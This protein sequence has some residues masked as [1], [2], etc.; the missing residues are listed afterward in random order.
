MDVRAFEKTPQIA[1]L[2]VRL[3]EGQRLYM[4]AK[5]RNP[6]AKA[7][8]TGAVSDLLAI[9][10]SAREQ[11]LLTDVLVALT[12]QAEKD[13]RAAI[14][15]RLSLMGNVPLRLVLQLAND[16]IAVAAPVLKKSPVLSDLDLIYIIKSQGSAYWQAIA[17]R[18]SLSPQV[19]DL[20]A[21]TK[22]VPTGIVLARNDRLAL[23]DH[24]VS[25][26][27]ILA[28]SNESLARPLLARP[29]LPGSLVQEIYA[30]A[31]AAL[32]DYVGSLSGL[33]DR[34]RESVED[35]V[36]EFATPAETSEFMPTP[37]MV[38]AAER[39]RAT[40]SLSMQMMVDTLGRGQIATF[41]ACF[42]R[43]TGLSAQRVHDFL[44]QPC[45]KGMAIACRAFGVQKGDFSRIYLMTHRMR[46]R[47]RIVNQRDMM[48]TLSYFDNIRPDV[49]MRIVR[50][51]AGS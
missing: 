9:K 35:I 39:G 30:H 37:D 47:D 2:L 46:S 34:A 13:L 38:E 42:A 24:A 31:G 36:I 6:L 1:P 3:H 15:E 41:I 20:L 22:D 45:P 51:E 23:T 12:R 7:E 44:K 18:E 8:L 4:L 19:I 32:R 14:A 43:Y 17:E 29:E 28:K 40:G 21:D 11:E 50:R 49:A 5:D 25:V 27:A 48:E 33:T 26:L 16:E 10:L